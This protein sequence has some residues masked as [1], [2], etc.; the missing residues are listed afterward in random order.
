MR[1]IA[2]LFTPLVRPLAGHR[3]FPLWAVLEHR[4]RR[5]G[6]PYA[7][8]VV[9]R[10]VADGFVIPLPF[11]DATQWTKNLATTGSGTVRWSGRTFAVANPTIVRREDCASAFTAVQRLLLGPAGIDQF[12]RVDDA[13]NGAGNND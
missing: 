6:Q 2:R 10:R 9:A 4:G 8:P 11:G 7:T 12:V 3:W 1:R 13:P 5:S